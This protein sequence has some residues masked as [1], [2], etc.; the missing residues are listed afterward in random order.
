MRFRDFAVLLSLPLL[1]CSEPKPIEPVMVTSSD[2]PC[3]IEHLKAVIHQNLRPALDAE[4]H[5][6]DRRAHLALIDSE[7]M[8]GV[9]LMTAE[10]HKEACLIQYR[11]AM[12]AER[13][14]IQGH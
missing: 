6:P 1:G 13:V 5:S 10:W 7:F 3:P 8:L 2:P 12:E 14:A 4:P 9:S 11:D